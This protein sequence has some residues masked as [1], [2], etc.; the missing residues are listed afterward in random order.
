VLRKPFAL[1]VLVEKTERLLRRQ[2]EAADG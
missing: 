1:D 2:R